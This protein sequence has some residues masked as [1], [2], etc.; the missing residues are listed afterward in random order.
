MIEDTFQ[1]LREKLFFCGTQDAHRIV[2]DGQKE[3]WQAVV[4]LLPLACEAHVDDACIVGAFCSQRVAP[5][6]QLVDNA[7]DHGLLDDGVA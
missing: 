7:A 2:N 4:D 1:K 5:I 3:R 6:F